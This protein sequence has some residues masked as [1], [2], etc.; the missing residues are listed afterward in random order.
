MIATVVWIG[1]LSA[2][3]LIV[4]PAARKSINGAAYSDLLARIQAR[5]Q[6][7]GWF[8]MAVLVVTGLFQMSANS[9]YDGFLAITNNWAVAILIK[10]LVIGL[11][12]LTSAY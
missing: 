3:S 10:H 11:L 1:S 8:C 7:L 6:P 9:A 12:V 2:L 5:I 4:I